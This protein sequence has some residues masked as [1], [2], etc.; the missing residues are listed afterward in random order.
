MSF[1]LGIPCREP[2]LPS[3]GCCTRNNPP[4]PPPATAPTTPA[5]VLF[6]ALAG[7]HPVTSSPASC[8]CCCFVASWRSPRARPSAEPPPWDWLPS[9]LSLVLANLSL[10]P[11]KPHVFQGSVL[12]L[13]PLPPS[14][15]GEGCPFTHSLILLRP[16]S[17]ELVQSILAFA[18]SPALL[19]SSED[20][21]RVVSCYY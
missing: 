19:H 15:P 2:S 21:A 13:M 16:S 17:E 12:V 4:P 6:P 18:I 10:S 5:P 8:L 3:I 14:P 11:C 20:G 7:P 1:S 9:Q